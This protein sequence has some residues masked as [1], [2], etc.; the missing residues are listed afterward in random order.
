MFGF[1]SN[2]WSDILQWRPTQGVKLHWRL[3]IHLFTTVLLV[4]I[5]FFLLWILIKLFDFNI[6]RK[7]MPHEIEDRKLLFLLSLRNLIL[8]FWRFFVLEL[9]DLFETGCIFFGWRYCSDLLYLGR[10][11][12]GCEIYDGLFRWVR[13]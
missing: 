9:D 2:A 13:F 6:D 8:S 1:L 3:Q 7:Q 5:Y 10:E 12:G 4:W 11:E